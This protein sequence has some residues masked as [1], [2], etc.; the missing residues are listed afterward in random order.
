MQKVLRPH[1]QA[2]VKTRDDVFHHDKKISDFADTSA[3]CDYMDLVVSVDTS[4]AH[5]CG[6][7]GNEFV[8]MLSSVPDWRWGLGSK[9]HWYQ[10]CSKYQ[11]SVAGNWQN[12]FQN[13][14]AKIETL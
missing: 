8:V 9:I 3:L 12:V 5:L 4:T 13:V 2:A 10:K 7:L 6:A 11:Q 14:K 1:E